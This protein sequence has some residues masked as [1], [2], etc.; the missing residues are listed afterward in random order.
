MA[1]RCDCI[2]P[3]TP[4]TARLSAPFPVS[5]LPTSAT[6]RPHSP[7]PVAQCCTP[8]PCNCTCVHVSQPGPTLAQPS[9]CSRRITAPHQPYLVSLS[10]RVDLLLVF[11]LVSTGHVSPQTS[12][13]GAHPWNH[14]SRQPARPRPRNPHAHSLSTNR[15]SSPQNI[16]TWTP[17]SS[18][19][20]FLSLSYMYS[21]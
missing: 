21:M 4:D 3:L 15:E 16:S 14:M 1:P 10:M 9:S 6:P 5:T 11:L 19:F 18:H 2:N 20:Q 8:S 17:S 13:A 12:R 7:H